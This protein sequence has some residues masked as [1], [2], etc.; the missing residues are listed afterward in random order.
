MFDSYNFDISL[1]F[2]MS[3]RLGMCFFN[4][5]RLVSSFLKVS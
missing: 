2:Y 5:S 4:I 3:N 1:G